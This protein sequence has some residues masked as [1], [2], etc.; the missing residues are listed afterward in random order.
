[1][2]EKDNRGL[3]LVELV[4]VMAIM[5][6]M[7]TAVISFMAAGLRQYQEARS[8]VSRQTEA[9]LAANQLQDLLI[10]TANGINYN[11]TTKELWAYNV[12]VK[13]DGSADYTATKIN[14]NNAEERLYFSKYQYNPE[15]D[16][17]YTLNE[18]SEDQLL[19]ENVSNFTADLTNMETKNVIT[20]SIEIT[21]RGKS[22]TTDS[23][24][25]LRNKLK[26][27]AD[28]NEAFSDVAVELDPTVKNVVVTPS[29][30][31][32]WQGSSYS[33]FNAV[34]NG[35]NYPAQDVS[36]SFSEATLASLTDS[37]TIIDSSSGLITLGKDETCET[38]TVVATSLE[39][40]KDEPD[41]SKW[42][43]GT[44]TL[45][46]K[47]ITGIQMGMLANTTDM[48][49]Q[50]DVSVTGVHFE[51]NEELS[52]YISVDIT[53]ESG[54]PVSDITTSVRSAE[55]SSAGEKSQ[56]VF[57]ATAPQN[58]KGQS[59]TVTPKITYNDKV[60]YG[61]P[62][63]VSFVER[64]IIGLALQMQTEDG[65]W[66]DCGNTAYSAK[67]GETLSFR[68]RA[69][70]GVDGSSEA[71]YETYWL[72]GDSEW[73]QY[74]TWTVQKGGK[75][76]GDY[77]DVSELT[78]NGTFTIGGT[79][80]FSAA[81]RYSF[82][83][84]VAYGDDSGSTRS[85]NISITIPEV[86]MSILEQ[87]ENQSKEFM[88]S[89][90][91]QN[92]H[93]V[94][95]GLDSSQYDIG[96]ESVEGSVMTSGNVR[97]SGDLA[98]LFPQK[99]GKGTVK[100]NLL[101]KDGNAVTLGSKPVSV[102]LPLEIG[103]KNMYVRTGSFGSYGYTLIEGAMYIPAKNY[104]TK[105]NVAYTLG[106]IEVEYK[107]STGLFGTT[108]TVKIDNGSTSYTGTEYNGE[109]IWYR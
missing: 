4:A 68:I 109:E 104:S 76:T 61:E 79:S 18:V 7:A 94:V 52:N 2:M 38:L 71:E 29:A 33:G 14:W 60:Y 49:V 41:S 11:D 83:L 84:H 10:D 86:S 53:D 17:S 69:S 54:N 20:F 37:G 106:G 57:K 46:N 32:V 102:T 73:S 107:T 101:D 77:G 67:R 16:G 56:Y 97:I 92:I 72:P 36:W 99:A 93:F 22:Y 6:I 44:A 75:V 40:K 5:A 8:E 90:E 31:T 87:H 59:I 70:Y 95:A 45:S 74:L 21:L 47:Y 3:S 27:V 1:M 98:V 43:S 96:F 80:R 105:G 30:A 9:Q 35:L 64:K 85:Q 48:S 15:I 34:V 82:A 28:E 58:Y 25:T 78:E 103:N 108:R 24:V 19:A 13:A 100:F 26:E 89:G 51:G 66:K 50:A 42:V 88:T 39:S 65:T 55:G 63:K 12:E 23:V 91:S 62:R 81:S